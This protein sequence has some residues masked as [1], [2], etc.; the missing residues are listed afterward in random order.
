MAAATAS[1]T[2][3]GFAGLFGMRIVIGRIPPV[4]W[5]DGAGD[6]PGTLVPSCF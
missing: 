6:L 5:S 4:K 3:R 2:N 1:A